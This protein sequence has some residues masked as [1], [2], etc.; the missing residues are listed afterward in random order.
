V[1]TAYRCWAEVDLEAI[2]ENLAW[3]RHQVGPGV[4]VLTVVKADAYGHGLRHIAARLM[5]SGTDIFGVA[6]LVEARAIRAVG[7]GWPILMLGACLPEEVGDAVRDEVMPVISTAA[8]AREFANAA[9]RQRRIVRAHLKVDTGMGRLGVDP[10]EAFEL[11]QSLRQ[12]PGLELAGLCTHFA[13]AEDDPDFTR[14]QIT[15]F[16]EVVDALAA[17]GIRVPW[18]HASG[19]AALLNE[20]SARFNLVRPGLLVYGI[21]PPGQ[22]AVDRHLSSRVRPVL[23]WKCRVSLVKTVPA[24]VSLSYGRTFV[25]PRALRVATLTVGYGDGYP[26]AASNVAS[27]LIGGRRCP[28]VG[29]VTMD[30]MLVDVSHVDPVNPGDEVV[31]VGRQGKQEITTPE[32]AG[33]SGSI[34]WEILTGISHRV[35]R[36]YLGSEA[37]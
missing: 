11:A 3:I 37:A 27:V 23:A 35:P 22:R 6:N 34:P 9:R 13:A 28:V 20:E 18:I 15:R 36:I 14:E 17:A 26:R 30:Q 4:Q 32:L 24:G 33:W 12:L 21:V 31:L 19:S 16:R 25:A 7:A 1:R 5:Q 2:R 29:R 10:G 8:E